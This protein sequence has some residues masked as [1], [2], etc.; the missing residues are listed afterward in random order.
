MPRASPSVQLCQS[1]NTISVLRDRPCALFA[2]CNALSAA[3][4][5]VLNDCCLTAAGLDAVGVT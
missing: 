2:A 3:A 4:N 5:L 1:G